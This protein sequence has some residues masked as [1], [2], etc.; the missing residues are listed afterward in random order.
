MC[1]VESP[2]YLSACLL[3]I[4]GVLLYFSKSRLSICLI[5]EFNTYVM[6]LS[7]CKD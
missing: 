6:L 2:F 5:I 4:Y 7:F 1:S 3:H